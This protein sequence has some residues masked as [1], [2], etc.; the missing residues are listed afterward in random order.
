MIR[1]RRKT[2]TNVRGGGLATQLPALL[3]SDRKHKRS[4]EL[5]KPS[6]NVVHGY[7]SLYDTESLRET[8]L[9]LSHRKTKRK[10]GARRLHLRA[11]LVAE[12]DRFR[13]RR[14]LSLKVA[15]DLRSHRF[16]K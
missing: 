1:G 5:P 6:A 12:R 16:Q 9:N 7:E 4:S 3:A 13:R 11:R 8:T 10:P 2:A 15:V 14:Q